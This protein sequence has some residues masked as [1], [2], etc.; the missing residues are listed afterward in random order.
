M[1][2]F[3][4]HVDCPK[5]KQKQNEK[6]KKTKIASK[7]GHNTQSNEQ[8]SWTKKTKS[9]ITKTAKEHIRIES[10]A[11]HSLTH[12]HTRSHIVSHSSK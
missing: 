11:T 2:R 1:Y 3:D 8:K 10:G 9:T 5:L 12:S 6:E 7:N 4:Y